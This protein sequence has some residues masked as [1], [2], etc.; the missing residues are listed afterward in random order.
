M[1]SDFAPSFETA[2]SQHRK[3]TVELFGIDEALAS[4]PKLVEDDEPKIEV[5]EPPA[6]KPVG[7]L[8]ETEV[9]RIFTEYCEREFKFTPV[10]DT[11]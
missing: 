11:H 1:S 3:Q 4:L 8:A 10:Y 7:P 2:W 6:P 9:A 5:I